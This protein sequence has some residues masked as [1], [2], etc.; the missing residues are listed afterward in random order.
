MIGGGGLRPERPP[1]PAAR[2][3][4]VL[5]RGVFFFLAGIPALSLE[6]STTGHI[7]RAPA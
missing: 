6:G 4:G 2:G 1:P 3:A 7:V 5:L